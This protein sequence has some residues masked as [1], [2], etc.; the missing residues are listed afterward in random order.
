MKTWKLWVTGFSLWCGVFFGLAI[1]RYT[2]DFLIGFWSGVLMFMIAM[3]F[4]IVLKL[5]E[6]DK[7]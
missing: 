3:I 4:Q 7:L 6:H 5:T 2:Q 1:G